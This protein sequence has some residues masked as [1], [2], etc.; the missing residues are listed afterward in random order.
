M[1]HL[2]QGGQLHRAFPISK[3][4]MGLN[5]SF[6]GIERRFGFLTLAARV[7]KSNALFGLESKRPSL[8]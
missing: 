8:L 2:V 4:S 6:G 1:N 3:T 5:C 7:Y